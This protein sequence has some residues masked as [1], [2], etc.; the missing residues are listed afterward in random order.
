[1]QKQKQYLTFDGKDY[2]YQSMA[3]R[4]RRSV[5]EFMVEWFRLAF[6]LFVLVVFIYTAYYLSPFPTWQIAGVVIH[7]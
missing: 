3:Q 1:M 4:P 2:S 7:P 6:W 5:G